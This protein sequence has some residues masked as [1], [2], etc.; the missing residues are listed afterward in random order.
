MVGTAAPG[1]D[2]ASPREYPGAGCAGHFP[3]AHYPLLC[4]CPS[5]V[6]WGEGAL[7]TTGQ[8]TSCRILCQGETYQRSSELYTYRGM[9]Y[10]VPMEG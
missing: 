7:G 6:L 9:I 2:E 5:R 8:E 1:E 4:L 3:D 10:H